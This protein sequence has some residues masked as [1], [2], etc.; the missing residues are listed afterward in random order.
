MAKGRTGQHLP[1]KACSIIAGLLLAA[2]T[3]TMAASSTAAASAEAVKWTKVNIPTEGQAG[4][5][6][7]ANGSDVQH[8]TADD[9]GALYAYVK[10]LT[11]TLYR[12]ADGGHSWSAIGNVQDAIV[13]IAISPYDATTIYY[14]TTSSVYRSVDSGSKFEQL[15]ANPGGAG[16]GNREITCID[17]AWFNHNIIAVGTR[18]TDSSE[19][20]G[21]YTLDESEIIP[22]WKDTNIG[23]YDVYAVAFSPDYPSDRQ[24]VAVMTD[25]TDTFSATRTGDTGWGTV[26]G[27]ATLDK[28]NSGTPTQV[29]VSR[30]AAIAFPGNYDADDTGGN[31]VYYVA[32]DTGTGEGDVYR[33]N[34]ADAPTASEATD[35]G[36][37]AIYGQN[38]S[39]VTGLAVCGDYPACMLL[40]GA[41]NSARTYLSIDGGDS[42]NGNRKEP[43]GES[44]TYVLMAADFTTGGRIYAATSGDDSAFSVSRDT[45]D[46]WNQL[47]LIDTALSTIVDLAPS[48]G[49]SQDQTLFMISYGGGHSLWR[50]HDDGST[51]ER[52]LASSMTDVDSLNLVALPPQYGKDCQTVFVAGE[53]N[54]QPSIWEST[55]NG[56]NYR[57]RHT[58]DPDTSAAFAIDT[59]AIADE[60]TIFIGSYDGSNGIVYRTTNSGFF[61][62][63]GAPAGSQPLHSI[64]ISPDDGADKTILVG[65]IDG[66]VYLSDNNGTTFQPLPAD[67]ISPPLSGAVT[68]AFDPGFDSNNTVYAAGD[69]A[70]DGIYRFVIGTSD[71]RESIDATLPAD[72]IVNQ[73]VT[74]SNGALYA[75][76]AEVDG[77]MERCLNP[78]FA[79]GPTFETVT[80]GLGDGVT[81]SGLW[82]ADT[83]LWSVNTNDTRLMTYKDTLT[84]PV[85]L[86]SPDNGVSG[87]GSLVDYTIRNVNLDWKTLDGATSYQW[88]CDYNTSFSSIPDGF[89]DST[90]A[91]SARLP[92]IETATKYYWRV[93]ASAPVLSPWSEKRSF[94]TSL[95]TQVIAL[96]PEHPAAGVSGVLVRPVFQWTAVA[97]AD[98]YELLVASDVDFQN[99]SIVKMDD[100]ALPTNAW[101]SDVSLDY[102]TTYYWKVRAVSTSTRSTWSATGVLMTVSQ[103]YRVKAQLITVLRQVQV[104]L[105]PLRLQGQTFYSRSPEIPGCF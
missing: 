26:I 64:S 20:G 56:Q 75:A 32:I 7:L 29:A 88:Q 37:T 61:Y 91:S 19:F 72:A 54:G 50:S 43:T 89:E 74:A 27:N 46:T 14:A 63:E 82:Q 21:V 17:A 49:Y 40:A 39:D 77:G 105:S 38:N 24:L 55:D 31:C 47:S 67:A 76:N 23:S 18:D 35:L 84:S 34:C 103:I 2:T 8:L 71:D 85:T 12:S 51:W 79:L 42:W 66:W 93:R 69:T 16:T 13:G 102:A 70:G 45:G 78:T 9:D 11:Y 52:I 57:R 86:L 81:L 58:R 73:L 96:K 4:N 33:I 68:V 90:T 99:P 94:T 28:D 60:T 36:V 1:L 15:P 101:Q 5:W 6:V 100:Y 80:R 92:A 83:R 3:G 22:V 10:G 48:P 53:S 87:I 62:S 95:D 65:N 30:S 104:L 41:A 44:Q 25:E 98:S 97:G 59:W